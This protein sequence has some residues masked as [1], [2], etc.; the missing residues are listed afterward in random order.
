MPSMKNLV[1]FTGEI[2]QDVGDKQE[3]EETPT[4]ITD[5]NST[6]MGFSNSTSLKK[7]FQNNLQKLAADPKYISLVSQNNNAGTEGNRTDQKASTENESLREA[8]LSRSPLHEKEMTSSLRAKNEG[9]DIPSTGFSDS[10]FIKNAIKDSLSGIQY[11]EVESETEDDIQIEEASSDSQA[12][13]IQNPAQITP[14]PETNT[15]GPVPE[16]GLSGSALSA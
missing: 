7:I 14:E 10:D 11:T 4:K 12:N 3:E 5:N 6:P 1:K 15:I 13:N 16:I 9:R 8:P 2:L